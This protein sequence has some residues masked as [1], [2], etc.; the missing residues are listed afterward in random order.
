MCK[1]LTNYFPRNS[2]FLVTYFG[3]TQILYWALKSSRS[4]FGLRFPTLD[5]YYGRIEFD[6]RAK[7][8]ID[9]HVAPEGVIS[10]LPYIHVAIIL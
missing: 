1:S 3:K 8:V 4:V 9:I 6:F 10:L 2:D 5:V 7:Y